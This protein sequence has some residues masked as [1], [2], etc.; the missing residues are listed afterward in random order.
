MVAACAEEQKIEMRRMAMN[1]RATLHLIFFAPFT[2]AVTEM[3]VLLL[4]PKDD[5]VLSCLKT[6][7][8]ERNSALWGMDR[9][10]AVITISLAAASFGSL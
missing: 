8:S 1:D 6:D 9:Y 10:C 5:A 7:T 4:M 2:S 3:L